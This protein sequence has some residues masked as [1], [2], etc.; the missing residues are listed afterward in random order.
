MSAN[1]NVVSQIVIWLPLSFYLLSTY[2]QVW[3]LWKKKA[4]HAL[5]IYGT[6]LNTTGTACGIWYVFLTSMPL[7]YH[8]ITPLQLIGLCA[9]LY[10]S[11][12]YS[13][14]LER[15]KTAL[16]GL[17]WALIVFTS[18]GSGA[19]YST[20]LTGHTA[21]WIMVIV[22]TL[23]QLPQIIRLWATKTR[24]GISISR[25][26]WLILASTTELTCTLSLNVPIQTYL[27]I[28]RS[29]TFNLIILAQCLY[30]YNDRHRAC[31][32]ASPFYRKIR[33]YFH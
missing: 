32:D 23:S 16:L 18:I 17:Y 13:H 15:K 20:S 33:K 30:Y 19:F 12:K 3:Y 9:I 11:Y 24:T 22:L 21:G 6:L 4:S 28:T 25:I 2:S 27:R 14:T 10:L 8:V 29:L 1:A 7:A 31:A 26:L 5:S